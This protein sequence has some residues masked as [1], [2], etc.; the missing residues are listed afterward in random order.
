MHLPEEPAC[1]KE[2]PAATERDDMQ[3]PTGFLNWATG[4]S[5]CP[6]GGVDQGS[7]QTITPQPA[8]KGMWNRGK[9]PLCCLT[10]LL[11]AQSVSSG[12]STPVFRRPF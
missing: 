8:F 7:L 3:V 10:Q 12:L 4:S 6:L 2:A 9:P 11:E 1:Q 5:P